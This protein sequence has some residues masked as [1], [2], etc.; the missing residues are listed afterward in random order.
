MDEDA[1]RTVRLWTGLKDASDK[2]RTREAEPDQD[3][4]VLRTNRSAT[5]CA[6]FECF[7][8]RL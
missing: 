4:N 5:N 2:D 3:Y 6:M 1:F 7:L 8:E